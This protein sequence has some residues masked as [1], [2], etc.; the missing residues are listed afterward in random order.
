MIFRP[1][2][3]GLRA[4][5]V[6]LVVAYHYLPEVVPGGYIGV[7]VFFVIS[8]YLITQ[9]LADHSAKSLSLGPWLLDFWARRARRLLPNA[10]L[11]MVAAS[12]VGLVGLSDFSIKRL[13]SDVFW[14]AT[15]SVNWL[16]IVRAIDYL[17]WDDNR[18]SVLLNYW[19][20]AIEEQFYL[21]WPG[22]LYLALRTRWKLAASRW[23]GAAHVCM[24]LLLMSLAY[25]LWLSTTQLTLA[26]FSS[27]SRA[28][29]LLCGAWLAL[30]AREHAASDAPQTPQRVVAVAG[31]LVIPAC[32]FL[33]SDD[34][35]HPG[36]ATLLPVLA[37]CAVIWFARG[38]ADSRAMALL[39]CRPMQYLGSRSYSIYLWHW[40]V[41]VLGTPLLPAGL[42]GKSVLLL[43]L[44]WGFAEAAY[45]WLEM[46]ARFRWGRGLSAR[47]VAAMAAIASLVVAAIGLALR[48][49]GS[50]GLRES[51]GL[52]AGPAASRL[53]PPL[54][55]VSGDLPAIY[56]SGCHLAIEVIA[57]PDCLHGDPQGT[58]TAVLF[59]DSHA[60]QWFPALDMVARGRS[61]RLHAWTKSGCPSADVSVWNSAA[62]GAYRQCDAWRDGIFER[63]E[64]LRPRVVVVS[65]LIDDAT[66]LVDPQGRPL[67]GAAAAAAFEEGLARTV[68]RLRKSGALVVMLRDTP[69]PRPDI[70]DCLYSGAAPSQCE[71]SRALATASPPLD[72]I[73]AGR[74]GAVLWDLTEAICPQGICPVVRQDPP[75]VVYRDSNHLTANFVTRLAPELATRWDQLPRGRAGGEAER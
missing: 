37:T 57:H 10:L 35:V 53:L 65:N 41:M 1:D 4:V 60:A 12:L 30:M 25:C 36:I 27:P 50:D 45:R 46:P 39:T 75:Q 32:G 43:A 9:S 69:R 54:R 34:T 61:A 7:D 56:A 59:G 49:V 63:I 47:R 31:L 24:G 22:I 28:W 23:S 3:E 21:V 66:V 19:S 55:Q 62:R 16:F 38:M 8:G 44:S 18:N 17:Q 64:R 15:Y 33:F 71:L 6:V 68:S 2:I 13:G 67:R 26:F 72:V 74:A 20:L 29:E 40:P 42:A 70:L 5:S 73:A 14:S 48:A 52:L 58:E 51:M 11:V